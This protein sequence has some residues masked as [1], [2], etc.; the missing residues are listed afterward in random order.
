MIPKHR[1]PTHPGEMLLKEFLEPMGIS[2]A[3]LA[4]ELD[5]PVQRV[6]TIIRGKRG[7]SAQTAILLARYFKMS[8]EFWMNLQTAYDLYHAQRELAAA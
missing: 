7:V 5:I 2:Q 6:N 3:K 1:A 4:E 8:P